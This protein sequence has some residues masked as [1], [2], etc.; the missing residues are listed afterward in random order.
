V[1]VGYRLAEVA[2]APTA[3]EHETFLGHLGPDILG[4]DFNADL[5][6][7]NLMRD[8][9][10]PIAEA[11]LD[12]RVVAGLGMN[13][14]AEV[15]FLAGV[16][17]LDRIGDI[18]AVGILDL[19]VRMLQ[20]NRGRASRVT[21]GRQA[22]GETSWVHGRNACLRCGTR[23]IQVTIGVPPRTRRIVCCPRCQRNPR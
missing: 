12:Q 18:D 8:P 9:D 21:T 3:A 22:R 19:G 4:P 7:R 23:L 11:L 15:C 13:Y 2:I 5:A 17:P 6:R 14:V 1:A 20:A 16:H 10:R